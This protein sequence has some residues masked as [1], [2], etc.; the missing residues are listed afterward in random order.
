MMFWSSSC[1]ETAKKRD[2][3]NRRKKMSGKQPP[4][5][6]TFLEKV[7]GLYV[8]HCFCHGVFELPLLRNA[9]K[10]HKQKQKGY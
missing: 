5:P 8:F 9:P 10:R 4:P 6:S 3:K 7:F 2:K 1:R